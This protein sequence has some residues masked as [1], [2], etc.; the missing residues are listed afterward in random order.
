MPS[1]HPLRIIW[2]Y[3]RSIIIVAIAAAV[4]AY[5]ASHSRTPKYTADAVVQVIPTEQVSGGALQPQ[6]LLQ[7]SDVYLE[8]SQTTPVLAN[9]AKNMTPPVST[10]YFSKHTSSAT[11]GD[12][13]LIDLTGESTSPK[14]AAQLANAYAKGFV[15]AINN[16][17]N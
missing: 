4:L 3:K 16:Q 5:V 1:T 10:F 14:Q 2:S 6:Q 8:V 12:L 7:L 17:T 13:G 15:D 9:S 11:K